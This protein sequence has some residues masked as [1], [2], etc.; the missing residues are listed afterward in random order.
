MIKSQKTAID[1]RV[2]RSAVFIY[3]RAA[4]DQGPE[5]TGPVLL[6]TIIITITNTE[7]TTFLWRR[8]AYKPFVN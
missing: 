4:H 6:H 3:T 5:T 1:F 2:E 8:A 7:F